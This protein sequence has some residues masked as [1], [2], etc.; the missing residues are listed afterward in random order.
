MEL[1]RLN[2]GQKGVELCA[3]NILSV[4]N[5]VLNISFLCFG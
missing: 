3:I 1:S 4:L 2:K 5:Q